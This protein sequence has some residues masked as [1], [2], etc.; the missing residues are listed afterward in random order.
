MRTQN[1]IRELR[2]RKRMTQKALADELDISIATLNRIENG[3]IK[4][5]KPEFL[6]KLS[7]VLNCPIDHFFKETKHN[8][9]LSIS[10]EQLYLDLISTQNKRIHDLEEKIKT[11]L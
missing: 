7:H 6:V 11:K 1:Y 9:E 4:Q 2:E 5:F 3:I 10:K 8:E